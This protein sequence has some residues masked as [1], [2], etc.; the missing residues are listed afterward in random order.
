MTTTAEI[1]QDVERTRADIRSTI[2]EIE[3]RVSVD[4]LV[5]RFIAPAKAGTI[6]FGHLF[7]EA[8]RANPMAL[9]VTAV[10][11]GWLMLGPQKPVIETGGTFRRATDKYEHVK[12]SA[13]DIAGEAASRVRGATSDQT[14]PP[15]GTGERASSMADR[16]SSTV[17]GASEH[18]SS[19]AREASERASRLARE[20]SER[21]SSI[22][23]GASATVR[24]SASSALHGTRQAAAAVGTRV[25]DVA[26]TASDFA[27]E[28]PVVAGLILI[29]SG[30]AL[31]V[32]LARRTSNDADGDYDTEPAGMPETPYASGDQAS[33]ED[34]HRNPTVALTPEDEEP[35]Y[36]AGNVS[37]EAGR[38]APGGNGGTSDVEPAAMPAE[39]AS[40]PGQSGERSASEPS[41]PLDVGKEW[42]ALVRR[43][44]G[45][46][47]YD[48]HSR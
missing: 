34:L 9:G 20:A 6:E 31:A 47:A 33:G 2:E 19:M 15:E 38:A 7:S 24:G 45:E 39:H 42:P 27:R 35:V 26:G 21:A 40:E 37:A 28:K 14:P 16:A 32:L 18:A 44:T 30:A 1:M 13:R 22:A 23:H 11:L 43:R 8:V 3:N 4:Q 46:G 10:G 5:H 41:D 36:A 25:R 12:A 29:L 17:R 48:G